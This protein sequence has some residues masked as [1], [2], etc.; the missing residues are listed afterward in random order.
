MLRRGDGRALAYRRLG[1]GSPVLC[2]AGGPGA[3][4]GYLEDL[5]GLDRHFELIVPDWRGTGDSEP[6]LTPAGQGFDVL[7]NDLEALRDYLRLDAMTVLAHS[8]ACTTTLVYAAAHPNRVGALV[9]V[10]PSRW[11]YDELDDDTDAIMRNRSDEPWY[12]AAVAA[13]ARLGEGAEP[14]EIPDL[15]G[16]L[17]P[18]SY[19][20]WGEREQAHAAMMQPDHLDVVRRFWTANV[21][22]D[23]VRARLSLVEAP[24]LVITGGLDAATGVNAGATWAACF[25]N[26]RHV[27][28]DRS[29]HI[30]WVDE[31]ETFAGLVRG[32]LETAS[33]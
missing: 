32:F 26:G 19:A 25:P 1:H 12:P 29:G 2:L 16:A 10:A 6:A 8:A 30:P 15:L 14:D 21:D 9:L 28:I 18:A 5:G 4:A 13:K 20:R 3:D 31:P 23:K 27:N 11:L 17:G 33:P 22:G 24:V 7:S